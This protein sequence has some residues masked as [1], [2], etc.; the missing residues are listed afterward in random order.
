MIKR[1]KSY[2]RKLNKEEKEILIGYN[3]PMKQ[4]MNNNVKERK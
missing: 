4:V 1:E 2:R 3:Q